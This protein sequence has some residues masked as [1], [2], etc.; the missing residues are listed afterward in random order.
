MRAWLKPEQHG[1]RSRRALEKLRTRYGEPRGSMG[2]PAL[3]GREFNAQS[4]TH[5]R[6]STAIR[7]IESRLFKT[8]TCGEK[9]RRSFLVSLKI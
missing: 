8:E 7:G 9:P 5:F 1:P 4:H 6:H 2:E 3:F